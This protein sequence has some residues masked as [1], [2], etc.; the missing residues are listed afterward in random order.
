MRKKQQ[1]KE[2]SEEDDA[3]SELCGSQEGMRHRFPDNVK[4]TTGEPRMKIN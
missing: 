4:V 1:D 2:N 3:L